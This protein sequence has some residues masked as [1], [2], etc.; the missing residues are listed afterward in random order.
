MP[1]IVT[2]LPLAPVADERDEQDEKDALT[3]AQRRAV[4]ALVRVSP[5]ADE[6][7]TRFRAAGFELAL[8]GGTVRDALLGRLH[9]DLDFTTDAR[10]EDVLRIVDGWAEAVWDV[11]IAFGTVGVEKSGYKLEIT[12]YRTESYDP[13]SRKP[14]VE[15]GDTLEGDLRR[16]DFTVNAMAVALPGTTFVDPYGGLQDL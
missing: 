1:L 5:V 6:L 9:D 7:G 8:V 2:A 13:G 4:E 12:T 10:P 16:R 15:Y 3:A 11:G 14:D